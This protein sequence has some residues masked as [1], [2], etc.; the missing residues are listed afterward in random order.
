MSAATPAAVEIQRALTG[1][2]ESIA[3]AVKKH[4]VQRAVS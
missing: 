1:L 2:R 4:A 3:V